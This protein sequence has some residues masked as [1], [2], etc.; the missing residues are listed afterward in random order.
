MKM[1]L[2]SIESSSGPGAMK[3]ASSLSASAFKGALV[4]LQAWVVYGVIEF[5]LALVLP[6]IWS[7]ES[8]L[9]AWQWPVIGALFA[10][11][12]LTGVVLGAIGGALLAVIGR[13]HVHGLHDI[14]A[15]STIVA[16][17]AANLALGWPLAR[18]EQIALALAAVLGLLFCLAVA[19]GSWQHRV[20][21]LGR[22][23]VVC[24]LLLCGPWLSREALPEYSALAKT[25]ATMI[26]V[27]L[28][29]GA[30]LLRR[31]RVK[32]S[33]PLLWKAVNTAA[34][35]AVLWILTQ[36][37][38]T[39]TTTMAASANAAAAKGKPNVVVITMDTVRADHMS[40]Y[41]YERDTTPNLREFARHAT[42]YSRAV[43]ASDMTLPSHASIFTGLYPSWHGAYA[44]SPDF[45][46]GRPLVPGAVTLAEVL[47]SK[48]YWTGAVVANHSFLQTNMGLAQGFSVWKHNI[49]MHASSSDRPFYLRE[50]ARHALS[51]VM[52]T[53]AF[54][55]YF[56]RASDINRDAFKILEEARTRGAFFLFLN[57]MDAHIPLVPPAPFRDLFPGRDPAFR[58]ASRHQDLTNM[59][60]SGKGRL[61]ESEKRHLISQY[62]GSIAYVDSEIARLFARLREMNLYDNT[63]IVVTSD[64]GEAFGEH[65]LMQHAVRS[66]YEEEVHVPLLVK[67]PG[68]QQP[69]QSAVPVSHVDIMPTVLGVAGSPPPGQLHGRRLDTPEQSARESVFSEAWA[70]GDVQ[71][72]PKLRGVR[73]AAYDGSS[74]LIAGS[75]GP[76]EFYDL[77]ND[78]G[79]TLNRYDPANPGMAA[80][81]ARIT[82]WV[83]GIPKQ[84]P[85]SAQP[86]KGT[87]NRIKSLGYTQCSPSGCS[88]FR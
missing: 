5:A 66:V 44:A 51:A 80:L 61:T 79:E 29:A 47:H 54:D 25:A 28:I 43:A 7:P 16:A 55:G 53:A 31:S 64:H 48:G 50:G 17:F 11:Y 30:A 37:P 82:T 35:F 26:A 21:F 10:A 14:V 22:P 18:S 46:Y 86:D 19:S 12:A 6:R 88:R 23:W 70:L 36:A 38:G 69:Q 74:K 67:L 60:N 68:Q 87:M 81:A 56:L 58:P 9:L 3:A 40:V 1:P 8:T 73:R 45:A 24:L 15:V 20:A 72:N 71:A 32:K 63:L 78:P 4:G 65:N 85:K 76:V 2:S 13:S 77:A 59:V 33:I 62:D 34:G 42:V 49:A 75:A 39:G 83:A 84:L 52:S 27:M 41:G 57:Y